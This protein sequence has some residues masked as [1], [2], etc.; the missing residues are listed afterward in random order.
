MIYPRSGLRIRSSKGVHPEVRRACIEFG[1]WLR[2]TNNFP[3]RVVIYLKKEYRIRN[4]EGE[5][6]TATFFAPFEKN[7]EPYIRIATGDYE[8][9]YE[10]KGKD[11]ALVA[12]L[13]SIAHEIV[14]YKQWIK[15][16]DF[17]EKRAIVE[18]KRMIDAYSGTR[19]H[20]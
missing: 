14:H 10:K 8:E 13:Y 3:I 5:L 15:D 9:L 12:Y 19:E 2:K 6:V 18:S 1:K 20:P 16:S 7:V 4:M 11:S 17:D